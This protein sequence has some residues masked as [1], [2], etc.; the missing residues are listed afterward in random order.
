MSR[1]H[2]LNG[3]HVKKHGTRCLGMTP[4]TLYAGD[5]GLLQAI[6]NS[7]GVGYGGCQG[8]RIVG[9]KPYVRA[10]ENGVIPIV[11]GFHTDHRFWN[12]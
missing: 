11:D 6:P 2:L 1:V 4:N 8:I 9:W 3:N 5:A 12:R 7:I 10:R